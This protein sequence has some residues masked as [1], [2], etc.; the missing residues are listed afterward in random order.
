MECMVAPTPT[1]PLIFL[2]D[3]FEIP[4]M[5]VGW[6]VMPILDSVILGGR[7]MRYFGD[8]VDGGGGGGG[9]LLIVMLMMKCYRFD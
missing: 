1:G 4:A 6:N 2:F 5:D 8:I 7:V 9:R 3:V